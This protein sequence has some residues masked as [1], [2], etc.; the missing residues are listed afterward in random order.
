MGKDEDFLLFIKI[1]ENLVSKALSIA[2]IIVIL[3]AIGDLIIFF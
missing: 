1:I 3:V 2:M